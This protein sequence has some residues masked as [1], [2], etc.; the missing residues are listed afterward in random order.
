MLLQP[1]REIQPDE[2]T[3]KVNKNIIKQELTTN[4]NFNF[5]VY[6]QG[7]LNSPLLLEI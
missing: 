5:I 6:E 7:L 1:S 4:F 3:N 2:K